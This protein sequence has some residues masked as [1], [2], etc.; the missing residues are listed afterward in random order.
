VSSE[1]TGALPGRSA[2]GAL[3]PANPG[4]GAPSISLPKGGGAI[5]GIGEKFGTNPVTGTGALSVPI[6]LSPGRSGFSP[7]LSLSYDSGAGNGPFGFGWHLSLP[8]VTRKTDKGLPRYDDAAASDVFLLSG[9]EDLVPGLKLDP[10]RGW[11]HMSLEDP[12]HAPGYR[13][14]RY[15]PRVEGLFARVERWTRTIDGDV[16]WRSISPGNITTIYGKD[17]NSRIQEGSGPGA[18]VFTWLICQSHDDKGNAVVYSYAPED[19]AGVDL[20]AA[21]ERNRTATSRSANR[22]LTSVRYGNRV[23]RLVDP[24]LAEPDWMFEVVFD[25]GEHDAADPKPG[26]AGRW[27][28]RRDAFSTYRAGFE[29]RTYRLCRRI[30]MFHHFPR[31]GGRR[32]GLPGAVS[33]HHL[34]GRRD[35]G[36]PRRLG[37]RGVHPEGVP[38]RRLRKLCRQVVATA[39]VWLQRTGDH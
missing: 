7:Q 14:D 35:S 1:V 10:G 38:A 15:R 21:N 36:Q 29:V 12:P 19:D 20:L 13:I 16:H 11:I 32:P 2:D 23:S 31:C 6:P 39:G 37:R 4:V 24:T 3:R 30:L 17:A 33:G 28:C 8:S 9:A 25:Y 27:S 5:R 26:G 34:Q 22:H 18:R